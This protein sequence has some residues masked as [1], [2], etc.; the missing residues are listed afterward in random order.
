LTRRLK[1]R[2]RSGVASPVIPRAGL[3]GARSTLV[4][5][6]LGVALVGLLALVSPSPTHAVDDTT[7]PVLVDFGISPTVVDSSAASASVTLTARVTDDVSG[8]ASISVRFVSPS[9]V[10]RFGA[11]SRVAGTSLDGTYQG[12][13]VLPQFSEQGTWTFGVGNFDDAAGNSLIVRLADMVAAGL[14]TSFQNQEGSP[15]SVAVTG[16]QAGA[17]YEFGSVPAAGCSVTDAED[18]ASSFAATLSPISGPR[19][20][21][22]LG[23]QTASCSYTDTGGASASA[24]ATYSIVDT[25]KPLLSLPADIVVDAT[26]PGGAAVSFTASAQDAVD[27][28]VAVTCLPASGSTFAIGATQVDCNAVDLAVNVANGSFTVTVGGADEQIDELAGLIE[29]FNLA[30]G[31]ESG[32]LEKLAGGCKDLEALAKQAKAQS[33]KKLTRAQADQIIAAVSRIR[34]VLGC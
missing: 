7:A 8:V 22:G 21:V 15:P 14:P 27:G 24:E 23:N 18:G 2:L 30:S 19:A 32:L 5:W 25:T 11:L 31:F 17:S 28:P 9:G 3:S 16:V 26:G 6:F 13:L 20:A 10:L 12:T 34:G 33:G 4:A 1:A 29:S